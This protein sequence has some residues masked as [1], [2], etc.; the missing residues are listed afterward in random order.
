MK[1]GEIWRGLLQ[2]ALKRN[3]MAQSMTIRVEGG[4]GFQTI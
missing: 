2:M 3:K 4:D 1:D